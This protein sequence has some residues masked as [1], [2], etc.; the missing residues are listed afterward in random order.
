LSATEAH[1]ALVLTVASVTTAALDLHATH[2]LAL[3]AASETIVALATI[4][5]PDQTAVMDLA[6]QLE[7]ESVSH[8]L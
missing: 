1:V 4:A 7:A 3:T 5:V 6:A 2:A 8:Q